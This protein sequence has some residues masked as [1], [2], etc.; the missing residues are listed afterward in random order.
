MEVEVWRGV[1]HP[2]RPTELLLEAA[3][4]HPIAGKKILDLGCGSGVVSLAMSK[5][6]KIEQA[7]IEKKSGNDYYDQSTLR[8]IRK[9][10]P[11]PPLPDGFNDSTMEVGINFRYPE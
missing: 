8:A 6:G 2:N 5:F 10:N 11:L 9:A 1:F 3:L 7:W 4:K